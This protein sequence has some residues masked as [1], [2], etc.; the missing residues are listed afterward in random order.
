MGDIS[1]GRE[2]TKRLYKDKLSNKIAGTTCGYCALNNDLF[3][4]IRAIR[5]Q[6]WI[7]G[8]IKN[9]KYLIFAWIRCWK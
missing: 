8:N 5:K 6:T 4:L 3:E 2:I 1:Y 7:Q 9:S